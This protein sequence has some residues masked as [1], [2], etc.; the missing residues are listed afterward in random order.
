MNETGTKRKFFQ[1]RVWHGMTA[2]AW[3]NMLRRNGFR[4]S[5][6]RY[7]LV[8]LISL[9]SIF[10]GIL[11]VIQNLLLGK[12]IDRTK[13]RSDPVFIIGHW[14]SG[15][16]LLHELLALDQRHTVP[17]TYACLAPSHFLV[18]QKLL[19]PFLRPLLPSRRSQD[20]VRV[21]LDRPQ[22]DEWAL[23]I[24][25]VPSPYLAVA[26]PN[27]LPHD[28]EYVDLRDVA[29]EQLSRWKNTWT[30][31]LKAVALRSPDRRLVLKSPLHT[32]RLD[33]LLELFPEA[34]FVHVVRDPLDVYASTL[35]LWRR[36]A[37]DEGLQVLGSQNLESFVMGNFVALYRSFLQDRHKIRSDH[38]CQIRY[39]DLVADP[40]NCLRSVYDQLDLG[41]F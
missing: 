3:F 25:G 33:V 24:L 8:L 22:E 13:L 41:E 4:V 31:F 20:D 30:R 37:E 1:L 35:H 28:P 29:T 39:E 26:F 34:R 23:C 15:T 12:K 6:S 11:A 7:H 38:I 9:A 14:K 5:P 16:T 19:G 10:N 27:Q 17:S 21:G 40:I 18:S 32:A 2:P 36:M